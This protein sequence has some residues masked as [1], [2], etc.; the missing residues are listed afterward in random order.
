MNTAFEWGLG[1]SEKGRA[2][3]SARCTECVLFSN[4]NGVY[5][6]FKASLNGPAAHQKNNEDK[7]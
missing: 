6:A 3:A 2:K 4:S 7:P 5:A 1:A